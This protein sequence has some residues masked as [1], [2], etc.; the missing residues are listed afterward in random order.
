VEVDRRA[1]TRLVTVAGPARP[2]TGQGPAISGTGRYVAFGS[3]LPFVAQDTNGDWDVYRRDVLTGRTAWVSAGSPWR[4]EGGGSEPAMSADGSIV[5]YTSTTLTPAEPWDRP[6]T[7]LMVRDMRAGVTRR[8]ATNINADQLLDVSL[9][10]A[11]SANGRFVVFVSFAPGVVPEAPDP[12]GRVYRHDLRTGRTRLVSVTPDGQPR[13]GVMPS[14]SATGRFVAYAA[15]SPDL[16]GGSTAADGFVRDMRTGDTRR[17]VVGA[18]AEF[19]ERPV[20]SGDGRSVAVTRWVNPREPH[21]VVFHLRRGTVTR[22]LGDAATAEAGTSP[23]LS[24]DGRHVAFSSMSSGLVPGDTNDVQDVFVRDMRSD[25][26]R[27]VSVGADGRQANDVSYRPV[28]SAG[29][30]FVAFDSVASNLAP[31]EPDGG[32]IDVFVRGPLHIRD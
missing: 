15:I 2:A 5:T 16:V 11:I 25:R 23:A 21:L 26:I 28:I 29:G 1:T 6:R 3:T 10:P 19:P 12:V 13:Y 8:I 32:L 7:D 4:A 30:R 22:V 18:P 24:A 31:D 9:S 27:R 17:L 20:I 14:V